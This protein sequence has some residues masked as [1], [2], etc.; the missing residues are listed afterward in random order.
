MCLDLPHLLMVHSDL[1]HDLCAVYLSFEDILLH[2]LADTVMGCR[3]L[4]ELVENSF[5]LPQNTERLLEIGKL[6]VVSF[7]RIGNT[8]LRHPEF[9]P[10][11]V[12]IACC[13]LPAKS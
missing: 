7:H 10:F 1:T 11:G 3:I 8:G 9:R 4:D 5:I 12:G 13:H 2:P 6:N